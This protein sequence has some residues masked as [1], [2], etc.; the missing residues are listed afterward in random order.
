MDIRRLALAA[1]CLSGGQAA[2]QAQDATGTYKR[3]NGD[4]V[5]V[6]VSG[7]K[8]FCQITDGKQARRR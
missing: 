8:L 7:G 1:A 6:S 4:L 2:A 5:R 3:A